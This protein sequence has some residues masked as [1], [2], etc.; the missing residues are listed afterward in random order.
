MRILGQGVSGLP[1]WQF[2]RGALITARLLRRTGVLMEVQRD[3]GP[4]NKFKKQV[5]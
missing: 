2:P 3:E 4:Q 5:N 1:F